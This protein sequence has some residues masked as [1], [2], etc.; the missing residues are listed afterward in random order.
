MNR[1][2]R[3]WVIRAFDGV[4]G[5]L[6]LTTSTSARDLLIVGKELQA[7]LAEIDSF[8]PT[9][10]ALEQEAVSIHELPA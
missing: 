8:A 6:L 4:L 5:Q 1:R 9:L 10:R 2:S 7:A 3:S